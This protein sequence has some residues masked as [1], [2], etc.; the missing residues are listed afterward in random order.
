MAA[1]YDSQRLRNQREMDRRLTADH[2]RIARQIADIVLRSAQADGTIANTRPAREALRHAIWE[3]LIRPYYI[4]TGQDALNG[5]VPL[6]PY[7]QLL[8]DG[9][10]QATRIQAER[11][12]ALVRRV[13]P[14]DVAAWLTGPRASSALQA[15]TAMLTPTRDTIG[16]LRGVDGRIDVAQARAALVRGRGHFDAY[17][18]WVDPNGYRLSDRIWRT[19]VEV[20]SRV[21]LL[22]DY[23]IGRGTSATELADLLEPFLTPGALN[24]R[25]TRP[26]G[27][28]GSYAAR[29]LARTEISAA[30]HRATASASIANPFVGGIQWRLS[31]SHP[32]IDICDDYARG[33]PNGD[34]IYPPEQVPGL[35]HPHC[36]CSTLPVPTGSTADLVES[37]RADIQAARSNLIGAASGGNPARARALAGL[38]NPDY[39][40]RS[41]MEGTLDE[42]VATAV[43]LSRT[44]PKPTRARARK[45]A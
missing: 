9:I 37:L 43:Q 34:G 30:A 21:D 20:R 8:V 4:G 16:S 40:T 33:G 31:A 7:A 14:P 45:Q 10:E 28:E 41:V 15:A 39:L 26:Y 35:P 11:Q 36:L 25:T 1:S 44:V 22:L 18:T 32:K 13:A 3:Q 6:S 2:A 42:A 17:H 27:S 23:H 19:S 29:R 38:L 24:Q 12:A 5:P